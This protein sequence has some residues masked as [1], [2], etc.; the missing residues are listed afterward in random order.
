MQHFCDLSTFFSRRGPTMK[1]MNWK[2]YYH[3]IVTNPALECATR[4]DAEWEAKW[5]A[6]QQPYYRIY[7]SILRMFFGIKLDVPSN[8]LH[9][10]QNPLLIQLPDRKLCDG[11]WIVDNLLVLVTAPNC[12]AIV[13]YG[14]YRNQDATCG[15]GFPMVNDT[16][17]EQVLKAIGM[18][19]KL[20]GLP[21]GF[22]MSNALILQ[23]MRIVAT[24]CLIANN[25]EFVCPEVLA[26]DE[27]KYERTKDKKYVE[28]AKRNHK[29]GWTVGKHIEMSPHLR[30]GCLALYWTGC[31]R[32]VPKIRW[33]KGSIV[34]RDIVQKVPQG[35]RA[36]ATVTPAAIT[37]WTKT[38]M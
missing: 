25:P 8:T 15:I 24:L 3:F 1:R 29:V 13:A 34:H 14:S 37:N 26:R 9:L 21:Q 11:D 22:A 2:E 18:P 10:P 20:S 32:T 19:N 28:R 35:W 30:N 36:L 4:L 12:L 33:R 27:E 5:Y 6:L 23:C 17:E 16:V 38:Q 7:P 31:G